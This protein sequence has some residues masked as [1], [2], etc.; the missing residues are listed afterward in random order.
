M[1]RS[2]PYKKKHRKAKKTI[3]IYGEGLGEEIFL[4][5]LRLLYNYESGVSVIIRNGKG[6]N[7]KS[8]VV[9]AI[10]ELGYFERRIVVLDNDKGEQEIKEAFKECKKNNV[11]ILL[12]TPC[13]EAT[14]LC[15]LNPNK[16]FETK[17]SSWLKKEFEKKY[18]SRKKR[19]ELDEYKN[20][21]PKELLDNQKEKVKELNIL[22]NIMQ[23][24]I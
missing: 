20:I 19:I 17:N 7:P 13:L 3:L 9:N 11:E 22:I 14:L 1:S 6:G 4:K 10:N 12:N 5:Y 23:G 21:F 2:N 24:I 8:I 15:I 18:M 16:I